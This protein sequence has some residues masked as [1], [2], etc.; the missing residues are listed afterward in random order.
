MKILKALLGLF[1]GKPT[2]G[3]T[4]C[5]HEI[6]R[7]GHAAISSMLYKEHEYH[8]SDMLKQLYGIR[9]ATRGGG[10]IPNLTY[11]FDVEHNDIN[12]ATVEF[13]LINV[14]RV[15]N[16]DK[17]RRVGKRRPRHRSKYDPIKRRLFFS[18][19][20]NGVAKHNVSV[21]VQNRRDF[22]EHSFHS[23]LKEAFTKLLDR[24][25]ICDVRTF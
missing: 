1:T 19:K 15:K 7:S 10:I 9:H 5:R 16:S 23:T 8:G 18:V 11:Q 20:V 22:F 17:H 4:P 3:R 13:E 6:I 21:L 12:I 24:G 25:D 14:S 2:Y